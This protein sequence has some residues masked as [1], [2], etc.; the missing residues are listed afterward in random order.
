[1]WQIPGTPETLN[2]TP[3]S[4]STI[5]TSPCLA[6]SFSPAPI[7]RGPA[8]AGWGERTGRGGVSSERRGKEAGGWRPLSLPASLV[9]AP[10]SLWGPP[11]TPSTGS[12]YC[13]CCCFYRPWRGDWAVLAQLEP[14]WKMWSS[15]DTTYPGPAPEKCRWGIL[16]VT[17]TMALSKTGKSLTPGKRLGTPGFSTAFLSFQRMLPFLGTLTLV[18]L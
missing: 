1:M 5:K 10:C 2:L 3:S 9:W 14:P 15:R 12:A 16:C 4:Q 7:P 11:A 17:T 13:R 6:S 18:F 8:R